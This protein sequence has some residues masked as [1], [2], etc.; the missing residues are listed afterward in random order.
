MRRAVAIGLLVV[1]II[2]A[3]AIAHAGV[4]V[5]MAVVG[6]IGPAWVDNA[7]RVVGG[8]FLLAVLLVPIANE[9]QGWWRRRR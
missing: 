6:M 5:I 3:V 2:V 8:V 7:V 1:G 4:E 9:L